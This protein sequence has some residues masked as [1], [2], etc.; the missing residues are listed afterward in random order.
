[1]R[2][3]RSARGGGPTTRRTPDSQAGQAAVA[4]A[5]QARDKSDTTRTASPLTLA[6][7]AVRIDTTDMPIAAVV[8]QVLQL[9]PQK[10]DG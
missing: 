7:D 4:E 10:L 5:I 3:P 9:V 6:P 8:E 1:M 2:L